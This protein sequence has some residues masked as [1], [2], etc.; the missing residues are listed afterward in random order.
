MK[1]IR[2][3]LG[4]FVGLSLLL[5][6]TVA[7]AL[8]TS[9][10]SLNNSNVKALFSAIGSSNPDRVSSAQKFVTQNSSADLALT[11]IQNSLSTQKYWKSLKSWSVETT[12]VAAPNPDKATVKFA[13]TGISVKGP[14]VA[15][16]GYYS[17]FKFDSAGKIQS[18]TVSKNS[19]SNKSA[20]DGLIFKATSKHDE[21][22]I[23]VN[24]GT[25][26]Q[27]TDGNTYIQVAIKNNSGS[28]KSIYETGG[29]YRSADSK[30]I[31]ATTKT[32]NCFANDQVI[33]LDANLTGRATVVKNTE[34][35]LEIPLNSI[36]TSQPWYQ[37]RSEVRLLA[38]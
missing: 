2:Y 8:P 7:S 30:K 10:N 15:F 23:T 32:G 35:V 22:G 33:Y 36:C 26:Y 24:S 11:M 29:T 4:L 31:N 9:D 18:W 3:I 19:T 12:G 21:T 13:K 5:N 14:V 16:N 28:P 34:S 20:L 27:A 38:N 1:K 17:N 6:S 25:I 37:T